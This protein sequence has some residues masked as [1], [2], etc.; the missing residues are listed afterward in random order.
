MTKLN[1]MKIAEARDALRKGD[2]TSVELTEACL[3]A[4]ESADA[5]GA[6]VHKTPDIAMERAK[7]ADARL[8]AGDA[9]DLCGVP[10][11]INYLF[12]T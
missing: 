1:S 2:V 9:P 12:C 10:L 7:A 4:I 6:F 11:C 8:Q 5:L 3:T